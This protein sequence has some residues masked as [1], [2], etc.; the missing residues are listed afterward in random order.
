MTK[1]L[2]IKML[3]MAALVLVAWPVH[4]TLTR[5]V[6]EDT[7]LIEPGKYEVLKGHAYGEL[8]PSDP[9]NAIITDL[10][11]AP[12]NERGNVEYVATFSIS[13]PVD[14]SL[15]SGVL[16]YTVPN[17]GRVRH[18]IGDDAINEGHVMVSSGW[19]ADILPSQERETLSVPIATNH[20]GSSI[21]GPVLARFA[22]IPSGTNTLPIL[23]GRVPGTAEPVSLDTKQ[24]TLTR[25]SSEESNVIPLSSTDWA[26]ADCSE[27]PFPGHPDPQKICIKD[28]FDPNYFYELV[29]IAKDP[30]VM[31]IGFAAV[32][33]LNSFL[34]YEKVDDVDTPN[35]LGAV[36]TSIV[37]QGNS[38][39]GTFL[40]SFVHLG[41]NQDQ[42]G[43]IVFDGI[44]PNIAFRLLGMNI[45]FAAPS[46][47]TGMY[48]PGSEGVVWW[49]DYE[50]EVRGRPT[51]SLLDRCRL[52]STCPKIME[53]FG[54]AEFY[55]LRASPALVGTKADRDIPLPPNVRRYY[56]PGVRHGG[57]VGSFETDPL[58]DP[59][60]Q[61]A[62]NPN[63]SSGSM[64]ALLGALIDWVVDDRLPPPS[65][66]PR[67]DQGELGL[68]TMIALGFPAI[69]GVP[70]PDGVIQP[71][72]DND[73]G[74]QF[75][76][77]NL[78]GV[79]TQQ[80]A[81]IRQVLPMLVPTVDADGNETSGIPSV[82]HQVPLGTYTGW[83]TNA[84]G[85]FKGRIRTNA[86]GFIP[87]AK[88]RA[89]RLAAGDPRLSLQERYGTHENFVERVQFAAQRLV[90]GRYLLQEDAD[91][92]I[93][94]A[95]A[96]DVLK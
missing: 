75:D 38:Q 91:W 12:R 80:P 47:S 24:A 22:N 72:Y 74:P 51:S 61:L 37:A 20:D 76:Y 66:Y 16:L 62:Q 55:H 54:S 44:N 92:L 8:N 17:R 23:R 27:N 26:Y 53:T 49:G 64:R 46:G 29:Y 90:N 88:T 4:A 96:S 36:I 82:Y 34:R 56:F 19:Q 32:R 11:Y 52:T 14:M 71:L 67:L 9:L 31:G 78:S 2:R 15:A 6:V 28:G 10:E 68:P 77:H 48:E 3:I 73:Y 39:S 5:L 87:F 50:D 42:A 40:R 95:Q 60:C 33:D 21:I 83:N 93:S 58:V 65:R 79:I 57:G 7:Q 35:I 85:I 43:R 86:G 63:A 69:P 41:F 84:S 18:I 1:L 25:R 81:P 70:L 30:K 13:K 89:E 45:R 94:E 59:C